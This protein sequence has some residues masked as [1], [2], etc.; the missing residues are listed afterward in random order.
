[1]GSFGRQDSSTDE[2]FP[3]LR[4]AKLEATDLLP[5]HQSLDSVEIGRIRKLEHSS[6][7]VAAA[8]RSGLTCYSER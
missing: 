3:F 7:S 2:A 5:Y 1:M 4:F 8:V 6:Q